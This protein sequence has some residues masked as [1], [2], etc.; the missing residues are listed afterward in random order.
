MKFI[1]FNDEYRRFDDF[2]FSEHYDAKE[3][4]IARA[5]AQLRDEAQV[6]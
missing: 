2:L 6:K 3:I 4:W 5:V 1:I